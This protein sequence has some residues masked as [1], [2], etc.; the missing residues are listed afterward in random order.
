MTQTTAYGSH[1]KV[2]VEMAERI[3]MTSMAIDWFRVPE[4]DLVGHRMSGRRHQ[5]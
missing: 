2:K 3:L 4:E 1:L 5:V